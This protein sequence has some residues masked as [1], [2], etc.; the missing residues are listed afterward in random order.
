MRY[1]LYVCFLHISEM[2]LLVRFLARQLQETQEPPI[3]NF[4]HGYEGSILEE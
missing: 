4:I 3:Y 2:N 1:K